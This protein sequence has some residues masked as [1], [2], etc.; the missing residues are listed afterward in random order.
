MADGQNK[1]QK[2]VIDQPRHNLGLFQPT[3]L[4]DCIAIRLPERETFFEAAQ[5]GL[6]LS[7]VVA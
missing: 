2:Y 7:G 6:L 5:D 4:G 1:K 3:G